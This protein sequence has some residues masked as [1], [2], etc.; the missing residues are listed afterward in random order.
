MVPG[1]FSEHPRAPRGRARHP[2]STTPSW[3]QTNGPA[4]EKTLMSWV[5]V[6]PPFALKR[7]PQSK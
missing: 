7:L 3:L 1:A 4:A 2:S 6:P 5:R